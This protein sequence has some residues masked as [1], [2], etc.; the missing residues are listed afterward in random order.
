MVLELW[1]GICNMRLVVHLLKMGGE[2]DTLTV[3][4]ERWVH[5]GCSQGG[6]TEGGVGAVGWGIRGMLS[7]SHAVVKEERDPVRGVI[8][9]Q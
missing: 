8:Q 2:R 5:G 1:P 4:A 7:I 9:E 3:W 6:Q